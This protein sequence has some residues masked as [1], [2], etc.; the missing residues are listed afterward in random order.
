ISPAPPP[1]AQLLAESATG[2]AGTV[3]NFGCFAEVFV[4]LSAPVLCVCVY[5]SENS[6]NAL[7]RWN[8][9]GITWDGANWWFYAN[10]QGSQN[11]AAYSI[12]TPPWTTTWS[13]VTLWLAP[14]EFRDACLCLSLLQLV[15]GYRAVNGFQNLTGF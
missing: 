5:S 14:V 15:L 6:L 8:H 4:V 3:S 7:S 1:T 13:P 10:G 2:L 12:A 9:I 11:G